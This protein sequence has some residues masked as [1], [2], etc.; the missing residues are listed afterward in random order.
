MK[1]TAQSAVQKNS[2]DF[3]PLEDFLI[4]DEENGVFI[5][6]DG[7]SQ[8]AEDYEG[9]VGKSD[10]GMAAEIAARAVHEALL[11]AENPRQALS[12]GVR[13]AI[14]RVAEYNRT[15]K[16][17]YPPACCLVAGCIRDDRLHFAYIGDSVIFLLRGNAKIQLAEQ[18]TAALG[19]YRRV[20]G[21][22]WSKRDCYERITNHIE[23]PLGYGVILGDMRAMD[24]LRI[25]SV[26]LEPGDRV[27]VS[28]D[29]LDKFLLYTQAEQ[30]RQL[31]PEE[32]IVR[33]ACYDEAPYAAFADDKS[34]IVVDARQA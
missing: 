28:S 4:C 17:S 27:I 14:V 30:L 12:D 18:Q 25:A 21:E 24:F 16:A 29:G 34:I 2:K 11:G 8:A 22:P 19:H 32:M 1:Y 10:A 33:S 13:E 20:S 15:A 7:V 3:K 9:L 5:V 26:P 23:N 31:A 6:T